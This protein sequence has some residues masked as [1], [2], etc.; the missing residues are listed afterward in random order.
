MSQ[1]TPSELILTDE[2]RIYHLD[3]L[4]G[5]IARTIITVGDP[6]RV[7]QVS[8]Y[9]DHIE[10]KRTHREFC[11]HTGHYKGKRLSVVS[12]GIGTDNIDIVFNELDALVNIDLASRTIRQ[13]HTSLTFIRMGT[14]GCLSPSLPVDTLLAS[15]A[16][17][18]IDGLAGFYGFKSDLTAALQDFEAIYQ[19]AERQLPPP[20]L[21]HAAVELIQHLPEG[22]E[23]GLTLTCT[24]FYGPQGRSL[25]LPSVIRQDLQEFSQLQIDG[26]PITNF[27]M[28]TAAIYLMSHLLG[29]RAISLNALIANRPNGA[30]S[31]NPKATVDRLIRKGLDYAL[32][33]LE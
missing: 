9:F 2:G 31:S 12:T 25:R 19:S 8:Q 1:L 17:I 33:L 3:L 16:S 20:Y 18:G 32:S 29:H 28:E 22:F 23:K 15:A 13:S 14:S 21:V 5:D 10:V 24:G 4:P 7:E 30:F 26:L 6:K 27:E 11:T